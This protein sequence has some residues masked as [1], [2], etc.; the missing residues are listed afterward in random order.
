MQTSYAGACHGGASEERA[1]HGGGNVGHT[2]WRVLRPL[3]SAKAGRLG[4]ASGSRR[5]GLGVFLGFQRRTLLEPKR[6]IAWSDSASGSRDTAGKASSAA[7]AVGCGASGNSQKTWAHSGTMGRYF[8]RQS[9]GSSRS[10]ACKPARRLAE[11]PERFVSACNQLGSSRTS[12]E[13]Q[14][15]V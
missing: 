6:G 15:G 3:S 2:A 4:S 7:L 12:L 1:Q 14:N 8:G 11:P 9:S 13:S 5:I 10:C